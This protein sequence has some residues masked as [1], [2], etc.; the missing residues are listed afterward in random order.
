VA[1]GSQTVAGGDDVVFNLGGTP[2]PNVGMIVPAPGGTSFVVLT[3]GDYEYNFYICGFHDL[4]A[5]TGLQF[6]IALNGTLQGSAH[7]FSS[8]NNVDS[9]VVRGQGIIS[10]GVGT[11]VTLRN[12]TGVG[13]V[14]VLALTAGAEAGAAATLSLKKLSP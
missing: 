9:Q 2:F 8:D 1:D 10:I 13:T 11:T 3:D 4:P 7:E 6:A 5:G 12:R 14:A